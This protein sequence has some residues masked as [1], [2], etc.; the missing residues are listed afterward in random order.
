MNPGA[1]A[2]DALIFS[3]KENSR[4]DREAAETKRIRNH[5][6]GLGSWRHRNS[7]GSSL[8]IHAAWGRARWAWA[9]QHEERVK[10]R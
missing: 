10:G 6:S 2:P 7:Q 3:L 9:S 1:L 5:E 8:G 4:A